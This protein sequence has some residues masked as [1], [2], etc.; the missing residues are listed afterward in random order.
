MTNKILETYGYNPLELFA[1]WFAEAKA[2][3]IN[4]PEAMALATVDSEGKPSVRIVL[5]KS[6]DERGFCFYTN[7]ES[8]KGQDLAHNPNAELNF[9]WKSLR[10]QVRVSGAVEKT[11]D[12]EADAYFAT[13]SR[14]SRIS[15][16]SSSQT[17]PLE[18]YDAL[19]SKAAEIDKRFEGKDVPRPPYW[20]GFRLKPN[21]MEFWIADIHRLHKRFVYERNGDGWTAGWLFP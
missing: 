17:R 2:S 7:F 14:E 21:R 5:L 11:S 9:Y 19:E 6:F 10:R 20:D 3:E 13:R 8:R 18:S 15:A 1:Q 4:D 12:E 16:W